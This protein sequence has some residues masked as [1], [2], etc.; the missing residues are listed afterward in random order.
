MS[1]FDVGCGLAAI[2]AALGGWRQG[3][4]VRLVTGAG[5]TLGLLG[6]AR[7][8]DTIARR[9]P[10]ADSTPRVAGVLL[11]LLFGWMVGRLIGGIA[12]R[13][14]RHRL[15][16]TLIA[17]DRVVGS[18]AGVAGVVLIV[19]LAAPVMALLPGWPSSAVADSTMV[20]QLDQ[21]IGLAPLPIDPSLWPTGD[22]LSG[23]VGKAIVKERLTR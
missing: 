5:A 22:E 17:S 6:A 21:R 8:V 11:S 15:P 9:L 13:W 7:H 18:A 16:E 2:A 20:R 23:A 19:W 3:I 4:V 12:G 14:I 1:P 10:K